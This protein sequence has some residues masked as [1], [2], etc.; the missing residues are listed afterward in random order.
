MPGGIHP[1]LEVMATWP[2]PNYVD[3]QTRSKTVLI[4]ACVLG[5]L[6][7]G[8]LLVRLWVRVHLQRTAGWDDWLM[9]IAILPMIAVTIACP[10]GKCSLRKVMST[11]ADRGQRPKQIS[12]TDIYGMWSPNIMSS[13]ESSSLP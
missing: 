1:P 7:L 11:N 9:L 2:T 6:S 4:F 8:L 13:S 3:P 12:L 10:L 5:P